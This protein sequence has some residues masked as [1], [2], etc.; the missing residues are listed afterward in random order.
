[1]NA[2]VLVADPQETENLEDF[3]VDYMIIQEETVQKQKLRV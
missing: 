2:H 3:N 1:M